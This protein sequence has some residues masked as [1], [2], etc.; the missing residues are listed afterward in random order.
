MLGDKT[1]NKQFIVPISIIN[2]ICTINNSDNIN[3][4]ANE[5]FIS[6][7]TDSYK[8]FGTLISG[9]YPPY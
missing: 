7:S 4:S 5:K 2:T 9:N 6:F 1:I 8:Y 3:V